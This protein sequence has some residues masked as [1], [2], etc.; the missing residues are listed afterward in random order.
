MSWQAEVDEIR[1][2]MELA[3]KMGGEANVA[4]HHA[5]GRFTVRERIG[6]LLDEGSFHAVGALAGKAEYDEAGNLTNFIP[7]SFVAGTGPMGGRGVVG[8]GVAFIGRVGC[9]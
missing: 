6:L 2:R 9:A 7:A 5:N 8:G 1:R 4:R 3:R